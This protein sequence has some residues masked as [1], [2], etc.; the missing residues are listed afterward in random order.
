MK[1]RTLSVLACLCFAATALFAQPRQIIWPDRLP[2][3][4]VAAH[5][6]SAFMMPCDRPENTVRI[7]DTL[8]LGLD[9]VGGFG[10]SIR[11]LNTDPLVYGAA[12]TDGAGE[13]AYTGIESGLE[14]GF[15]TVLVELC[16]V[17]NECRTESFVLGAGRDGTRSRVDVSLAGGETRT[18]GVDVPTGELF[19]GSILEL[20]TY[21]ATT[22][23]TVRFANFSVGDSIDYRSARFPGVDELD[24]VVCNVFGTCDTT[25]VSFSIA[26]ETVELP[27]CED[28]S[29]G[30]GLPNPALWL[31]DDVFVNNDYAVRP[32]SF[33]VATFDGLNEQGLPYGEGFGPSDAL[34]STFL[35]AS[36]SRDLFLKYFL[37][38]G[39][40]G[41]APEQGD[42]MLVE[43]RNADG[44]WIELFEHTG[45]RTSSSDTAFSFFSH[46][47]DAPGLLH[48]ALQVRFRTQANLNGGFDI[49]NLDYVRV[50]EGDSDGNFNDIALSQGPRSA[51]QRYTAIP[52][53]QFAGR[54]RDL[55]IREVTVGLS[56]LFDRSNNV[57]DSRLEVVDA[58]GQT[59][60][61]AALLSAS[62]FNLEPGES[63]F[64]NA[65]PDAP[66]QTFVANIENASRED[67]AKLTTRYTLTIDTD[68]DQLPCALRN[69]SASATTVITDYFA[70][71]DGSAESGLLP[72]GVGERIAVR[73]E[74]FESDT[75]RGLRFQFP[76]LSPLGADRQL[77]NLQV[78]IG[79]LDDEPEYEQILVRPYFPSVVV[80]TQNAFTTYG[81]FDEA[82]EPT[83]LIIPAGQFYI[84]WQQASEVADP[85]PVG[86]DLSNDAASEIFAAAG[87]EWASL[88]TLLPSVRGSLMLR[89]VFSES[90]L[91]NS[92]GTREIPTTTFGVAP[93]PSRGLVQLSRL[94]ANAIGGSYRLIDA[95]GRTVQTGVTSN[96]L[97]L[98]ARPGM[99]AMLLL[100]V[101]GQAVAQA[102]LMIH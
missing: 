100:G 89:P 96:Q 67:V 37:Q 60:L 68:Q 61:D 12:S 72:G 97:T 1:H 55:L 6:T 56:N 45:S 10:E 66:Y 65:V 102:R 47:L 15:D 14:G 99:Y 41:A 29:S 76:R 42:I 70:Y 54:E 94:P 44:D 93:N 59:V 92:S 78:Y 21:D 71:D 9:T 50:E 8:R 2:K 22:R 24:I 74:A 77:I 18:V 23:R 27:L 30:R 31:D 39:G 52:Y 95:T 34:T 25:L 28:F 83:E 46:A 62:Q 53:P 20:E 87:T 33:G 64:T 86:L 16:N 49:W 58:A 11:I 69:D 82:G 32:P 3:Q 57:S 17:T 35:D 36:D 80:D 26:T 73:Y 43:A 91:Q 7:G 90:V 4:P 5:A 101:D 51:L 84:G 13:L 79:E 75:L 48:D 85:I 98:A 81:L 38:L 88:S 40:R 63:V 19:C